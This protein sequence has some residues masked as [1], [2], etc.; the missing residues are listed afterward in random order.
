MV[1]SQ[2]REGIFKPRCFL[3]FKTGLCASAQAEACTSAGFCPCPCPKRSWNIVVRSMRHSENN[4]HFSSFVT[5]SVMW[6]NKGNNFQV[7]LVL[8]VNHPSA[9][10][11]QAYS[12]ENF[13]MIEN[14]YLAKR[15]K[16]RLLG[17]RLDEILK[18]TKL[19][20]SPRIGWTVLL[21]L[22]ITK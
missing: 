20:H 15:M 17:L 12:W 7:H 10:A 14:K 13:I 18:H 19:K 11:T 8:T 21:S 22:S 4:S 1:G 6:S 9:W 5:V 16:N 3:S 2:R